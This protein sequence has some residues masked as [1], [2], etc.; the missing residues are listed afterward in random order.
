MRIER[1]RRMT[2]NL[3][4]FESYVFGASVAV[5]HGDLGYTDAQAHAM[6]AELLAQEITH[7]CLQILTEQLADEIEDA[8]GM[9]REQ[10]SVLH[11]SF[12]PTAGAR[13]RKRRD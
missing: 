5:E 3:G 11:R 9:T 10:K 2:V 7:V 12:A 4:Q 8:A 6:P 13:T 1:H